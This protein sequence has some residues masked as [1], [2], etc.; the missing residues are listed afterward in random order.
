MFAPFFLG[1]KALTAVLKFFAP[2]TDEVDKE[3]SKSGKAK[4]GA[5]QTAKMVKP[6]MASGGTFNLQDEMAKQLRNDHEGCQGIWSTHATPLQGTG[7]WHHDCHRRY[8]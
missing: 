3:K 4:G 5:F 2:K 7:C 8:R 1:L 6:K